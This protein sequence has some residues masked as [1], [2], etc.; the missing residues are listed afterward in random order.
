MIPGRSGFDIMRSLH[1]VMTPMPPVIMLTAVTGIDQQIQARELG[2]ARYITKPT[3]PKK[4]VD[5][6]RNVILENGLFRILRGESISG[7]SWSSK[8]T[9]AFKIKIE[10]LEKSCSPK[11]AITTPLDGFDLIVHPLHEAT[12]ETVRKVVGDF[13]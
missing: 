10:S 2:V 4:L 5:A 13:I 1:V 3:T 7:S 12:A 6:I 11:N 8:D 9:V